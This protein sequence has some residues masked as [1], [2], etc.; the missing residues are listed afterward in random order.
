M[1]RI[2]LY[3]LALH[4]IQ[5]YREVSMDSDRLTILL[6]LIGNWSYSHRAGNGQLDND[7]LVKRAENNLA[8]F[9]GIKSEIED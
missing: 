8:E 2:D 3:Q 7:E 1:K 9:M 6:D 5:F 4:K